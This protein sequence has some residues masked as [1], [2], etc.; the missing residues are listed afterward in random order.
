MLAVG[1][2]TFAFTGNLASFYTDDPLLHAQAIITIGFIAWIYIPDGGQA[3]MANALRGRKDVWM[4]SIIQMTSFFGVM[5]PVGYLSAFTWG[6][7]TVGLFHG[8]LIGCCVSLAW[9]S[10]RFHRLAMRD[11]QQAQAHAAIEKTA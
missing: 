3:V 5:V 7:G 6:N 8:I 1:I 2:L 9:Q 4:P 11:I 10:L